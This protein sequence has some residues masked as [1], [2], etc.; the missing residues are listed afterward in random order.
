MDGQRE[1]LTDMKNHQI[2]SVCM[3]VCKYACVCMYEYIYGDIYREIDR[4]RECVCVRERENSP[5]DL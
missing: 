2:Y 4:E 5:P 3:Y 1:K